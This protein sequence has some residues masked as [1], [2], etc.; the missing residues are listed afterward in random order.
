MILSTTRLSSMT[1]LQSRQCYQGAPGAAAAR[2]RCTTGTFQF[3]DLF[4]DS[5]LQSPSSSSLPQ[6][7]LW[8]S[9][10]M[11]REK[12]GLFSLLLLLHGCRGQR[13][14]EVQAKAAPRDVVTM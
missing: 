2:G 11:Y 9:W 10:S 5:S 6:V 14:N 12:G 4:H 1:V 7:V 3:G 13:E 8:N